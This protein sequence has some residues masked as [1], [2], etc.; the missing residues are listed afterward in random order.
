VCPIAV[1][2]GTSFGPWERTP[3][4]LR[5]RLGVTVLGGGDD[6]RNW[7]QRYKANLEK[8]ASGDLVQVVEVVR[9]LA[10]REASRGLSAGEMRM[11]ARARLI[12]LQ[13]G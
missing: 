4:E 8:L 10:G 7:S 9:D 12:L 11:L 2:L 3:R 13:E 6:E 1:I 5:D